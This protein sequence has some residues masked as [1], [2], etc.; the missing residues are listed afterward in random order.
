M[1]STIHD[2][3]QPF[4]V[5]KDERATHNPHAVHKV[6]EEHP[7]KRKHEQEEQGKEEDAMFFSI[8]ALRVFI[9]GQIPGEVMPQPSTAPTANKAIAAYQKNIQKTPASAIVPGE[10]PEGGDE[11]MGLIRDLLHK[12]DFLEQKGVKSIPARL[13]QSVAEAITI[14]FHAKGGNA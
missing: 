14:A 12:L 10:Q 6:G 9:R 5:H 13:G 2:L 11:N 7:D 4:V 3:F 8:E 1:F